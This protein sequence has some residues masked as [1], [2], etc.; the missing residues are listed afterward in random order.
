MN[1]NTLVVAAIGVAITF[2]F[3]L[4]GIRE[5][6]R[7]STDRLLKVLEKHETEINDLKG[8]KRWA[9]G[10]YFGIAAL[11]GAISVVAGIAVKVI[12]H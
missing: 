3:L 9:S 12:F 6:I 5:E 4:W 2:L 7:H 10:A 1:D 11:C 8:D